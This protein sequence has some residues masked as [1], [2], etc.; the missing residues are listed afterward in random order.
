MMMTNEILELE[1]TILYRH[2]LLIYLHI[3]VG[4]IVRESRVANMAAARTAEV[5]PDR[6]NACLITYFLTRG[7][8]S[9]LRSRQLCSHSRASQHFMEPE[10]LIPCSRELSSDPI[11][12]HINPVH[13]ISSYLSKIHFNIVHP[14]TSYRL[15]FVQ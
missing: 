10:G 1:C 5:I 4:N 6:F 3:N 13:T 12:S 2:G 11:L 15:L 7:A 8:E 14:P 9:F